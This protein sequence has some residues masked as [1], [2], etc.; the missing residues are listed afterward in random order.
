M[1][2]FRLF[3]WGLRLLIKVRL[4]TMAF[5]LGLASAYALGL[6]RAA[7][8]W[9]LVA[10]A[11]ARAFPGDDLVPDADVVETRGLE[12]HAPREQVWSRLAQLGY[13]RAGWYS[14]RL[15]DRAWDPAEREWRPARAPLADL[16]TALSVGDRVPTGP[17][18]GLEV[19][20]ADEPAALVLYLDDVSARDQ[21]RAAL[22]E[23]RGLADGNEA[24]PDMPPYAVSWAFLLEGA[25]GEG[26]RL[27]ERV[28]LRFDDVS[29]GQRRFLPVLRLGLFAL[30]RS[31]LEGVKARSEQAAG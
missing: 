8:S 31:Q 18:I 25:P 24:D 26:T 16:P 7:Q 14:A 19:R 5:G 22:E 4:L 9:G 28:R 13:G 23:G 10:D 30:L 11:Q 15:L 3:G 1:G 27:I 29:P 12:I 17:V 2:M 21:L 6:R 20:V